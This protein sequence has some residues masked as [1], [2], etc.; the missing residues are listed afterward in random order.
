MTGDPR[1]TNLLSTTPDNSTD[2]TAQHGLSWL[3]LDAARFCAARMGAEMA[4][5]YEPVAEEG[6]MR[7]VVAPSRLDPGAGQPPL[8]RVDVRETIAEYA[9]TTGN[10]TS[11]PDLESDRR[12]RDPFLSGLGARSALILPVCVEDRIVCLL[13]VF[14]PI[15]HDFTLDEVWYLERIAK[16][17]APLVETVGYAWEAP[18]SL[19]ERLHVLEQLQDQISAAET[20]E[21]QLAAVLSRPPSPADFRVSPRHDYPYKQK[22]APIHGEQLPSWDDFV[23]VPCGDLSGGGISLW[24]ADKPD[25][26]EVVVALGRAPSVT[27]FSARVVY[28]REAVRAGRTMYQVGCQ[29]LKRIYL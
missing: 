14:R 8:Q 29:F 22:I 3:F 17:L 15:V 2:E 10:V 21:Q 5:V 27:H 7:A 1:S 13:G 11:S 9:L 28:V 23:E 18:A 12:F 4:G 26:R 16:A 24:L 20:N 19:N 25:F 6:Q